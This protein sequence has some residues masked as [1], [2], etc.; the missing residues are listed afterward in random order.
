MSTAL[1]RR[2]RPQTFDAVV[3][4][5]HVVQTL[6]NELQH[7]RLA[8]A[9][10]FCGPRGVGKTTMARLLAKAANSPKRLAGKPDWKNLD[11]LPDGH[12]IDIIEIDAASH[13]QVDNVREHIIPNA[14]TAPTVCQYKVFIID[15]VHMLSISAFNAL[16]KILEEP[17]ASVIFILAT[18]EAHRVPA[19]II[20][21]CQRFDFHRLQ[22]PDL[23]GRIESVAAEEKVTVD[24]SVI[25][26][27]AVLADG[28]ARDADSLFGQVL[29]LGEKHIT[30]DLAAAVLPRTDMALLVNLFEALAH[31]DIKRAL[32]ELQRGVDDG[33]TMS[34]LVRDWLELLRQVMVVKLGSQTWESVTVAEADALQRL[35]DAAQAV[36]VARLVES[37]GVFQKYARSI[38]IAEQPQFPLELAFVELIG[39]DGSVPTVAPVLPP[40]VAPTSMPVVPVSVPEKKKKEVDKQKLAPKPASKTAPV[41]ATVTKAEV[42]KHWP[43]VV[44]SIAQHNHTLG[45]VLKS[46]VVVDV[47][48]QN[49]VVLGFGFKLHA[50][51]VL[52]QNNREIVADALEQALGKPV[53]IQ[54]VVDPSHQQR[55]RE[56]REPSAKEAAELSDMVM[57]TFGSDTVTG[58]AA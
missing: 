55:Q 28:S 39:M 49:I 54:T 7:N 58:P 34:R 35:Q 16:L 27:I 19:T 26:S 48:E 53:A 17:P 33:V 1:Y 18:T 36:S 43:A 30:A 13:T 29:S 2:Y 57:Q 23:I 9:Y 52:S 38:G 15:E 24:P 6:I 37:I 50:E 47:R 51:R 41:K 21:R 45:M 10:L 22:L 14:Q 56:V 40:A 5:R 3:N 8:H 42:D 4:Q 20:S 31:A 32:T 25:R 44:S 11:D 46:S 12:T